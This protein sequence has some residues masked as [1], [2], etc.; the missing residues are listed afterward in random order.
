[1]KDANQSALLNE[2]HPISTQADSHTTKLGDPAV[3]WF[4]FVLGA[5]ILF[6]VVLPIVIAPDW[7]AGAINQTF[8]FLTTRF[9]VLYVVTAVG[10]IMFLLWLACSRYGRLQLGS[11]DAEYNEFAWASML[12][13]AGIGASL[14][15]WGAA[16]WVYYYTDP[17]M[18]IEP[19]SDEALVWAAGYGIFHWGPILSLIHI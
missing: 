10:T 4:I 7:S 16:E 5:G 6:S 19:R 13:C 18:G 17:P 14:I 1:M 9:G 2:R 15:Y 3:D 11:G 8:E 12:F